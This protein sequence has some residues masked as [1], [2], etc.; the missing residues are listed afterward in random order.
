MVIF[1]RIDSN[2]SGIRAMSI[3]SIQGYGAVSYKEITSTDKTGIHKRTV[4]KSH[5]SGVGGWFS[6]ST[7][8]T[9]PITDNTEMN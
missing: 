9:P 8:H 1:V 6:F 3:E 5:I 4:L 2:G 7:Y